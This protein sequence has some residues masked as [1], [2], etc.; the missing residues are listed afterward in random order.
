MTTKNQEKILDNYLAVREEFQALKQAFEEVE[1]QL[2]ELLSNVD[3]GSLTWAGHK[4]TLVEAERRSFNTE[5]LKNLVSASIFRKV[6][7]P[8]VK[9]NL[10]DAAVQLGSIDEEVI[11]QVVSVTSYT[12][13][14]VK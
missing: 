3:G 12:Q 1:A 5:A 6:T 9:T 14:R 7:E 11:E 10:F 4:F 2:K 13:L 8:T